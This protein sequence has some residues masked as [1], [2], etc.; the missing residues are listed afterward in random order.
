M[1]KKVL[2]GSLFIALFLLF[3]IV[4]SAAQKSKVRPT[5]W[6]VYPAMDRLDIQAVVNNASNGDTV[7]F[8]A[9]TYDWS[10]APIYPRYANEGAINIIDK[11]LTIKGEP[12]NLIKGPDSPTID[13]TMWGIHAFH[14]LDEDTNNDVTF[15]GLNIQHF[16]RGVVA[17]HNFGALPDIPEYTIPNA[18]NVTVIN[19]AIT[20]IAR[21]GIVVDD[22]T[23]NI[24]IEHNTLSQCAAAGI[25]VLY[26]GRDGTYW[27]PDKSTINVSGNKITSSSLV[28]MGIYAGR[29]KNFRVENNSI[30][31]LSPSIWSFGICVEGAKKG[32]VFSSNF[33]SNYR[34][35]IA[36]GGLSALG[37]QPSWEAENVVVDRNKVSCVSPYGCYGIILDGDLS[38]GHTVRRNEINLISTGGIGIYSDGNH[39]FYGQ[40]K[41]SGSGWVAVCLSG[42]DYSGGSGLPTYAHHESFLGNDVS[43]FIPSE[44]HYYLDTWT[45]ENKIF[46]FGKSPWT[47]KDYGIDNFIIGGTNITGTT[48][49]ALGVFSEVGKKH[50]NEFREARKNILF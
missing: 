42:A 11:T 35:G 15:M 38:S 5:V 36:V 28:G 50:L 39:S 33:V 12:G 13:G 21:Q 24:S 43:K 34:M 9:G 30:A 23:G 25:W 18:R 40:N 1:Y 41:I 10:E 44:A 37:S 17:F 6:H 26:S 16:M 45:H 20:D 31:T 29:T 7:Y 47:Y 3:A 22:A 2:C 8:H 49:Q 32:T 48:A 46:G 27:Q 4:P 19:C 14:V